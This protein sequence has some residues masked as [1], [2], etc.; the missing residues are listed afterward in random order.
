MLESKIAL[1]TGAAN[2]LGRTIAETLAARG[3]FVFLAD[4][5]IEASRELADKICRDG[6]QACAISVDLTSDISLDAMTSAIGEKAGRL[7]VL[8]NSAAPA[9]AL[10][11]PFPENMTTW[12]AEIG[13]LLKAPAVTTAKLLPLLHKGQGAAVVN[14]ASVLAHAIAQESAAYHAA[15]AG[16]IQFTRY[17]AYHQASFGVRANVILPGIV[18]RDFGHKLTDNP[19]NR[20]VAEAAVPLR[21]AARSNE[22]AEVCAFL[23]SD[24]ASYVTGQAL[25]V[26]GGLELGESFHVG[27][28]VLKAARQK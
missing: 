14:I 9:R 8:V 11:L 10:R 28:E 20:L 19:D 27:R 16:L 23:V 12:D 21:R 6:C 22:V 1:V 15:K 7:D 5:Q 25:T 13:I 3:A 24:A 4:L 2:G 18:D 26:D 17:L